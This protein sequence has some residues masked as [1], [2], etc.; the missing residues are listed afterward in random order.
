[1]LLW[2]QVYKSLF[3]TL[4]SI[5]SATYPEVKLLDHMI[6]LFLILWGTAILFFFFMVALL[7]AHQWRTGVP[8]SPHLH[9]HLLF[10]GF[11]VCSCFWIVA[12][13]A[14]MRY[15]LMVVLICIFLVICHLEYLFMCLLGIYIS[16]LDNCL[17][18]VESVQL[19]LSSNLMGLKKLMKAVWRDLKFLEF[20]KI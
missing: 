7:H 11:F 19:W 4:L 17:F 15:C 12:I 5:L 20:W 1:M 10:S 8:F 13:L 3:E 2:I 18:P 9:H 6:I 14:D 16:S